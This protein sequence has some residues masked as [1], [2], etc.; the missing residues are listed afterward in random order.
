MLTVYG[1][2]W[3]ATVNVVEAGMEAGSNLQ[4]S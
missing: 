3:N 1:D 2:W 4:F